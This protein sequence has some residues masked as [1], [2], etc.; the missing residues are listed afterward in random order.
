MEVCGCVNAIY[1]ILHHLN[2]VYC[3][4]LHAIVSVFNA[5]AFLI[6]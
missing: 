2:V 5:S 3:L 1:Y 4:Y 6:M